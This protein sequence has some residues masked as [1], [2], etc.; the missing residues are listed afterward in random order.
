MRLKGKTVLVTGATG[1]IGR[2][3]VELFDREG[4]QLSSTGRRDRPE[5]FPE[6]SLYVPGD[7][8]EEDHVAHWIEESV[9]T[10]GQ[11]DVLVNVHGVQPESPLHEVDMVGVRECFDINVVGAILTMK[12]SIP[13]MV[14]AG[15]GSIINI[16][17]RLGMVGIAGQTVYS[18]S[19]GALIMLSKGS[20]VEYAR[21]GI[22]VNV[23][24]P[25]LTATPII[26]AAF[27]RK[28]DPDEYRRSREDSIPIGR[29]ATPE[30]VAAAVLFL[31]TDES[32]YMTGTVLPVDGGYTAA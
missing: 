11:V 31:A 29:L 26:E 18:A 10:L 15:G 13:H 2:A 27:Q 20:A 1:G 6:S 30:D 24:A 22:R 4:A 3:I 5:S 17:S 25:G 9:D 23:V 28:A 14:E 16:A 19:K 8:R 32:S 21:Q 7:I 12:H